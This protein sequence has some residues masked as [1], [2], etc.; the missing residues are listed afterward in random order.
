M[1]ALFFTPRALVIALTTAMT[2]CTPALAWDFQSSA[3]GTEMADATA[4]PQ[5]VQ[6][7]SECWIAQTS[8]GRGVLLPYKTQ[9]EWVDF[10]ANMPANVTLSPCQPV[11]SGDGYGGNQG[12]ASGADGGDGGDGGGSGGDD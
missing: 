3:D 5:T 9:A 4:A 11:S 1:H 7:W 2:G 8:D 6:P 10:K 12:G